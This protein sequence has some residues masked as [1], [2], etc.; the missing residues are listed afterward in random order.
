MAKR[1]R[2]PSRTSSVLMGQWRLLLAIQGSYTGLGIARLV[3][4]CE[5][6]R[7]TVYRYLTVL[8]EAG[9][10]IH[11]S[12]VNG[13][14]RYRMLRVAELPPTGF[15]ALQISALHLARLELQPLAGATV[16]RELDA[17][18]AKLRPLTPQQAFR[19]SRRAAGKPDVLK[20]VERALDLRRRTLI[21]YRAASRGGALTRVHV[22][23]LLF[24]VAD[25]EPYLR[26]Y[27]VERGAER[28][29][30][31]SRIARAE[32]TEEAAT[33]RPARAPAA[34]YEH[35]VKAW[36]DDPATVKI[37]LDPDVA[38][39]AHEYPLV[40]NQTIDT[41]SDGSVTISARVAGIVETT[42]WILS[43]GGAAEALE[44]PELREATRRE[45]A[46]ALGKYHHPGPAKAR[47]PT[48]TDPQARSRLT[49]NENRRA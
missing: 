25:G 45:L 15:N 18:L 33:Y 40:P 21:E 34:A 11:S 16:V 36:S 39:L 12:V 22:E 41:A 10:P 5:V 29:Y 19:F 13:E 37:R 31:L 46:K 27:C 35:S 42:R 6:S 17:L 23:P 38:W 32:L 1:V 26:A 14:T 8:L 30:K 47:K 20:T 43:W 3:E 24:N 44:P 49:G 4:A 2:K 48:S 28:T 9:A 7:A